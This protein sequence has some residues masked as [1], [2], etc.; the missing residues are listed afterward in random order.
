MNLKQ[1]THTRAVAIETAYG[2][3]A[4]WIHCS[5]VDRLLQL[6]ELVK[7]K[8]VQLAKNMSFKVLL[9]IG[10]KIKIWDFFF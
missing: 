8:K 3:I 5:A 4:T 2:I 7:V 9:Q 1:Q 10:L 6:I